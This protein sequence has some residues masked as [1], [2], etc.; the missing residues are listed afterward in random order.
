[1]TTQLR[2]NGLHDYQNPT[3]TSEQ[4]D[5]LDQA[6][7]PQLS[8][9]FPQK[10]VLL[11]CETTGGKATHHRI[12]EIGL[13]VIEHGKIVKKWQTLINPESTIPN[14]ITQLTGI[15]NYMV[16][17][18]PIFA[19][20]ADELLE[21]LNDR[22]LVAHYARFD[23]GFLKREFDRISISYQSKPLCSVKFS[24]VM[25]P[26][27]K[28]HGLDDIIKRFKLNIKNRHRAMD[29]ALMIYGFFLKSSHIHR[30]DDIQSACQQLLKEH[31]LPSKI[32]RADVDKLPNSAGVYYFYD[33]KSTLLYVG[34]SVNIKQRV[35]NHFSQDHKN[36]KDLKMSRS[37][38]HIDF[39]STVSDFGAQIHESHQIKALNPL[40]NSRLRRVRKLFRLS[41]EMHHR[42]FLYP[43]IQ[44]VKVDETQN[45]IQ[46]SFGLFRSPKQA[47]KKLSQL[48]DHYFLCYQILGLEQGPINGESHCFRYHLKR[49]LGVCC[50]QESFQE[51]NHRLTL[52]LAGHQQ[53]VWPFAGAIL[54]EERGHAHEKQQ[55]HLVDQ[56]IYHCHIDSLDALFD[57]G[58]ALQESHPSHDLL[59]NTDKTLTFDGEDFDL[60]VYFILVRFLLNPD[61]RQINGIHIHPLKT[62]DEN[63]VDQ[64]F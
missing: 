63:P 27:Y 6:V 64:D 20:I 11:D 37:I 26:Q 1:M 15:N 23:Y 51:H 14:R 19:E 56:W 38:A 57:Q 28:R 43:Q 62:L 32:R 54:I 33:D 24:R 49:C 10:M 60:D 7:E 46:E 44:P 45:D 55:F 48:A 5:W 34:K 61:K 4:L 22:V 47:Q 2:R 53:K 3:M 41:V 50:S 29:D 36:H 58:Y 59:A 40:Y 30:V 31:T 9:G 35:L 13:L 8:S 16:K 12:T 17:S 42:G 39:D 18:A 21:I 25:Y 52:A